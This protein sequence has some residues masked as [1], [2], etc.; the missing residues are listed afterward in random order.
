[1]SLTRLALAGLA[2]VALGIAAVIVVVWYRKGPWR[3]RLWS[4]VRSLLIAAGVFVLAIQLVPYGRDHS[5]PTVVAE[6]AWDSPQTRDL[7]V[8]ACFDCHSNE[9]VWPWYSNVAPFSWLIWRD[10]ARGRS[11]LDWSEWGSSF[12]DHSRKSTETIRDGSMPPWFFTPLHPEAR[13]TQEEMDTLAAGL[14]A[15]FG[16]RISR[17]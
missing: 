1:M 13:L 16:T 14:E 17:G 15:T 3:G 7:A 11:K 2:L 4:L 9:T 6:P 12:D 5:N 10:V 8:R